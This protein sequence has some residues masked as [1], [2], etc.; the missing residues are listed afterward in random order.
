MTKI[1]VHKPFKGDF[2]MTQPFG[3]Y[4][5][6]NKRRLKH[7]GTDW[8]LPVGTPFLACFSGV[9]SRIEK[10]RLDGY[11][12]SIYLQSAC[13]KYEALYAHA[14]AIF[15]KKGDQVKLGDNLGHS[16]NTGFS[17]GPHIHFGLKLYGEYVDP[18]KIIG[19][20]ELEKQQ[21]LIKPDEYKIQKGD[22]LFAIA[23]KFYIG[24]DLWPLLYSANEKI[25]GSNPD[26]IHPGMVLKIPRPNKNDG[27]LIN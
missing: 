13:G 20:K 14:N 4:F 16:G 24:G 21:P 7:Q 10:F 5:W 23:S 15:V 1:E 9:I 22:T 8:A 12:K 2:R 11:G 18:E 25:I 17:T 27:K 26:L 6:Y 3:V 19:Y